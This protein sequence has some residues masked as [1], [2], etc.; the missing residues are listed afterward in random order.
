VTHAH[1]PGPW[2]EVIKALGIQ[3]PI[4]AK[5]KQV[6]AATNNVHGEGAIESKAN[7]RL[8]AAAPELLA[9]CQAALICCDENGAMAE[10]YDEDEIEG[11]RKAIA[12]AVGGAE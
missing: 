6:A 1:T 7:A 11:L 5:S 8:I 9:A 3:H 4:Y 2:N 12:K 10:T